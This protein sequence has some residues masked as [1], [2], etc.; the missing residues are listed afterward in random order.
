MLASSANRRDQPPGWQVVPAPA[1]QVLGDALARGLNGQRLVEVTVVQ[2][3]RDMCARGVKIPEVA[4]HVGRIEVRG[5]QLD[6][7]G[8][9]MT[10]NPRALV[11]R[12]QAIQV[13][14]RRKRTACR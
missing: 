4:D 2:C 11:L 6:L 1:V 8:V 3:R 10:V 5:G 7:D 14:P 12:R 9:G 13:V